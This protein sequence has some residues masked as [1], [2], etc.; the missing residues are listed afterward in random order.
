MKRWAWWPALAVLVAALRLCHSG[1]L[2]PEETLPL[3][4]AVQMLHGRELYGEIWFDKPPLAPLL[5][6]LWGAQTGWLLRLAGALYVV[7]ASFFAGRLARA[8]WG[9]R[10]ERFASGLVAF[11]LTF[12]LPA[13]VIPLASDLLM[14]APHAAAVWLAASGRPFP[15]GLAAGIAFQSN[16]KGLLVLAAC[17][18]FHARGAAHMVA[19][20]LV[21]SAAVLVWLAAG[22]A[23]DDY[24]R[25]VW[26][27]GASYARDTFLAAPLRE[28][29]GRTANWAGFHAALALGAIVFW[30]REPLN[31]RLRFIAWMLMALF[32]TI[33]GLRFFPRY[34]FLP[35]LPLAVAGARGFAL[36]DRR[37]L[38]VAV[39]ALLVPLARF[40]PR[41]VTLAADLLAG[42][43]HAWEDVALDR[44]SRRAA[45][46][47][48]E[49]AQPG[50]TLF[51]WGYRPEL[52]VYTRLPAASRFL[53]CQPL[54]GVFADRHL[55]DTHVSVPA[56]AQRNRR[57]LPA[58]QPAWI[59]DGLTPINPALAMDR[60]PELRSWLA[61][62]GLEASTPSAR[63]YR[64]R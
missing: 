18:L 6:L 40:A 51:V 25:Q 48:R 5:C 11:Y 28:G 4:A 34:Y 23:L 35:L 16:P 7:T 29:L 13:A 2:W 32:G 41:Y 21:P 3:A 61:A 19:G 10:E 8:L 31:L 47:V 27:L 12:W 62:Y 60:Y 22:D 1:I 64:R 24:F 38:A 15:A 37:W 49:R 45:A 53:E 57:E 42:R 54:T 55:F 30:R 17:L 20:F 63:I 39:L 36:L 52:Y 58:A 44:D 26:Q 43:E 14:L 50:D 9:E 46:L 56:T 33:L 59:V